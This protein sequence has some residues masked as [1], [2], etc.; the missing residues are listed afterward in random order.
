M[1]VFSEHNHIGT[2]N[3]LVYLDR[4]W[5]LPLQN[6]Y[7]KTV[8]IVN[9]PSVREQL[10]PL[11]SL[12]LT[13]PK[14]VIFNL[15]LIKLQQT[16]RLRLIYLLHPIWWVSLILF[17]ETYFV[18]KH[19]GS[20]DKRLMSLYGCRKRVFKTKTSQNVYFFIFYQTLSSDAISKLILSGMSVEVWSVLN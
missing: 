4:I 2:R 11:W 12:P 20:V 5:I 7:K 6:S 18:C 17:H 15:R 8:N 19:K 16:F 3:I 10:F 14:A 1:I 9:C 13:P